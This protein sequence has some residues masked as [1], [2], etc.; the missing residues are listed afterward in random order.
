MTTP[1][2]GIAARTYD[3]LGAVS[4]ESPRTPYTLPVTRRVTR[5]ATIDGG[6][7][8]YDG[9]ST[10]LDS[11]IK[12]SVKPASEELASALHRIAE[13]HARVSV[14]IPSGCYEASPESVE[15]NGNELRATF[16]IVGVLSE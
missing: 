3:P 15:M 5:T 2:I 1:R 6:A 7:S 13:L 11:Q 9:G 4:L 8:V 12:I 16:L 10:A 14:S